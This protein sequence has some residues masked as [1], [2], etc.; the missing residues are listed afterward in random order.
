MRVGHRHDVRRYRG[1]VESP[2]HVCRRFDCMDYFL[3]LLVC[4]QIIMNTSDESK[5]DAARDRGYD[6]WF[7]GLA[8][9]DNPYPFS[10]EV[11]SQHSGWNTGWLD[12]D[13]DSYEEAIYG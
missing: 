3:D 12:A 1:D 11:E 10:E 4:D 13:N 7:S 5:W 2:I 8:F 6:S 9:H